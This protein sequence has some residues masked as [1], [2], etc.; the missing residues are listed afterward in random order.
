[1]HEFI[2]LL[3]S[4]T[5]PDKLRAYGISLGEI[6][7]AVARANSAVGGRVIHQGNAEYLIRSVGWIRDVRDIENT[8]VTQ[9]GGTPITVKQL[10]DHS[11][12]LARLRPGT[13]VAIE[14]PYGGFTADA[15]RSR[16]V[17][18]F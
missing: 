3:R 18:L 12:A 17:L 2:D 9:R 13:R 7:S 6:Y 15:R 16:H 10:G 4:L 11:A 1:M 14:G 8:V 5:D